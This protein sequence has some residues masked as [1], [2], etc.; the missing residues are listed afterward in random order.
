VLD[1][2]TRDVVDPA[3]THRRRDVDALHRL[4][5]LLIGRPGAPGL[6][7]D[8]ER[9]DDVIDGSD[10]FGDGRRTSPRLLVDE[11]A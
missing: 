9:G 3:R 8:R 6:R 10:A 5:V 2:V 7:A 11:A 4:A 1:V